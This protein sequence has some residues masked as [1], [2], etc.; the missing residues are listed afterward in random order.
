MGVSNERQPNL[1]A[2]VFTPQGSG[3]KSPLSPNNAISTELK[4]DPSKTRSADCG[5]VGRGQ[6]PRQCPQMPPPT[7]LTAASSSDN[8]P[9][10]V[11]CCATLPRL[12]S[13][14]FPLRWGGLCAAN[15]L[16]PATPLQLCRPLPTMQPLSPCAHWCCHLQAACVRKLEAGMHAQ[17]IP[18]STAAAAT[19]TAIAAPGAPCARSSDQS[20]RDVSGVAYDSGRIE[21]KHVLLVLLLR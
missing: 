18:H 21:Q 12:C 13:R 14:P 20:V 19:T 6:T 8:I 1:M 15:R 2:Y 9:A 5:G 10:A 16:P 7:P 17:V 4:S 3:S 11:N